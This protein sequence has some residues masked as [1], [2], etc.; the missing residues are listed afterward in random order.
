MEEIRDIISEWVAEQGLEDVLHYK[1]LEELAKKLEEN[2]SQ[3]Y[4]EVD[5]FSHE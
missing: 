5:G 3:G 1:C 4:F 2:K